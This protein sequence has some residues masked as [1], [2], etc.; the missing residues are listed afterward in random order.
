[1]ICARTIFHLLLWRTKEWKEREQ[2]KERGREE[3]LCRKAVVIIVLR[4]D[5]VRVRANCRRESPTVHRTVERRNIPRRY[6]PWRVSRVVGPKGARLQNGQTIHRVLKS[7]FSL[8]NFIG[9]RPSAADYPLIPRRRH[10]YDGRFPW[11]NV[12]QCNARLNHPPNSFLPIDRDDFY[13]SH[14]PLTI[15]KPRRYLSFGCCER[16]ATPGEFPYGEKERERDLPR[17]VRL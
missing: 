8:L 5:I 1:M 16:N 7:T 17:F 10:L 11:L 2:R 9:R 14:G 13:D 6:I 15:I 3:R 4:G 12:T